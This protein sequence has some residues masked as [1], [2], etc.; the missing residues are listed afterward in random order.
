MTE[1]DAAVAACMA[2]VRARAALNEAVDRRN[3]ALRQL[4]QKGM[5][6]KD[7]V[8]MLGDALSESDREQA[9]VSDG[10]VRSVTRR[11]LRP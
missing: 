8:R 2:V 3:D 9:G 10:T 7:V 5:S 1:L 4:R 6:A 11:R